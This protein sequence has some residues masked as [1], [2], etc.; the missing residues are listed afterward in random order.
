VSWRDRPYAYRDDRGGIGGF[1]GPTGGGIGLSMPKPTRVVKWLLITNL[2][3]F[4][5]QLAAGDVHRG[6][7]VISQMFGAVGLYWWQLWRYV[8]F[9]FLH[10]GMW[11]LVLNMLAVY[12]LGAPLERRMGSR[13]FL[14]FYLLC[15]AIAGVT[16]V[17]MSLALGQGGWIP[18]VG[19]SGG[20][21]GIILAA[22]VYFPHF[23]II[24]LFFPVP[25][26]L[27]AV[28][29]FSIM[30]L[31][32]LQGLGAGG[33][34]TGVFWSQVAHFGGAAAAAVWIFLSRH[35]PAGSTLG[36]RVRK[37]S[38]QR[39]Q[40]ERRQMQAEVDRILEKIHTHGIGSLSSREKR[41]LKQAT[42]RQREEDKRI[43]KL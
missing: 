32:V 35:R 31:T 22:A 40:R 29:I 10:G 20:V 37:G 28:I 21:Y 6:V 36:E 23:R 26:R 41:L 1:G 12:F 18:I 9:Q 33:V 11:H 4:V 27:A 25:I 5:V 13:R 2:L 14:V 17:V 8:T 7:G 24:F 19:A 15:G 43:S 38:W 42:E 3:V 34:K 39:K 16:Y 30:A